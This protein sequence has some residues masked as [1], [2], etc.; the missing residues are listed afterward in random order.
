MADETPPASPTGKAVFN[1]P[2][3]AV[4]LLLTVAGAAGGCY[5]LM[6]L[7]PQEE[8]LA[9]LV[10]IIA[11]AALGITPGLRKGV[12]AVLLVLTLG[13]S[14][15]SSVT[16]FI[17]TGEAIDLAGQQFVV[18]APVFYEKCERQELP[19]ETCRGWRDFAHRF[20]HLYRPSVDAWSAA[21]EL[22]EA[23]VTQR[24][25]DMIAPLISELLEFYGALK[26]AK[27]LPAGAP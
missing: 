19:L 8:K 13:L 10:A 5:A 25:G 17:A 22:N 9:M 27:L 23:A 14:G 16:P 18:A 1:L 6:P 3:W 11:C 24:Y 20:K 26:K 4:W 15:C 2:P 21:V 7:T 12:P